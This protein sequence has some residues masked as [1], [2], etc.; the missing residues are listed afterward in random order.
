M[1]QWPMAR[2]D[3]SH[4]LAPPR[5]HTASPQQPR[6]VALWNESQV[7][8]V[9]R[10]GVPGDGLIEALNGA[11]PHRPHDVARTLENA[12]AVVVSGYLD[13]KIRDTQHPPHWWQS[14]AFGDESV[15][16]ESLTPPDG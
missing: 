1:V 2:S 7:V 4:S 15:R 14:V 11:L 5:I 13:Q 12:A 8:V 3:P 10:G 9:D 16:M 6:A